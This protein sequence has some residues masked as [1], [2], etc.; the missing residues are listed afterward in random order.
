[1]TKLLNN[2][3]FCYGSEGQEASTCI[4]NKH[5]TDHFPIPPYQFSYS[6]AILTIYLSVAFYDS[7]KNFTFFHA[8]KFKKTNQKIEVLSTIAFYASTL[9]LVLIVAKYI[10]V[11]FVYKKPKPENNNEEAMPPPVDRMAKLI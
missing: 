11:I 3:R 1:M 5:G 2:I 4:Q 7:I 8:A 9:I 6:V 10:I